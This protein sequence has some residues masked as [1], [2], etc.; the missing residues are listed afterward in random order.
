MQICAIGKPRAPVVPRRG[1][2]AAATAAAPP[3]PPPPRSLLQQLA[4][5]A[6]AALLLGVAS[7]AFANETVA[8]FNTSGFLFKDTVQVVQLPDPQVPL[9]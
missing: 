1:P 3:P 4:A 8:S 5:G 2:A 7:P 6:T 9:Q